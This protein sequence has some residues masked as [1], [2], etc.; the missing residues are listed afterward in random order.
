M[1]RHL[2]DMATRGR[3]MQLVNGTALIGR[4]MKSADDLGVLNRMAIDQ[5]TRRRDSRGRSARYRPAADRGGA[6]RWRRNQLP[7]AKST[8]IASNAAAENHPMLD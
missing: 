3:S 6:A 8:A 7:T 5:P 1:L 2:W 4:L